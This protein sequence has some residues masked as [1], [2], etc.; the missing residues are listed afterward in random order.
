MKDDILKF[1][2]AI[3]LIIALIFIEPWLIFWLCYFSG[4]LAKILIGKYLI[5][6]FNLFNISITLDK[7][8]LLA[9]TLGWIGS[10]FKSLGNFNKNHNAKNK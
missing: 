5:A 9:G 8:P 2:G 7:I 3:F 10:F 4:W 1:M 6:G